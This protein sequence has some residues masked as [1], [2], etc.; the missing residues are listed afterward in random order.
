MQP[1]QLTY[2]DIKPKV[3]EEIAQALA[4]YSKKNV[5]EFSNIPVHA[6][7]GTDTTQIEFLNIL[8]KRFYIACN[9]AGALAQTASQF[10]VVFIAPRACNVLSITEVHNVAGTNG[11]AVT[12]NVEKLTGTQNLDAGVEVLSSPF[13]LKGTANTVQ[14]GTMTTVL[15]SKQLAKGD[16]LALKDAG[17]LTT[18][19]D[20]CV[21]IELSY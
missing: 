16:R 14:Y 6:H 13:N 8:N 17:T 5:Y 11:G 10:G 18:L 15:T 1:E 19:S 21:I 20:V 9:L 2:E 3:I 7:T 4:V 12:L